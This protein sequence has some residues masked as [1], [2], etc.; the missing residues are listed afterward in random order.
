METDAQVLASTQA[1]IF[2]ASQSKG[3]RLSRAALLPDHLHLAVG[4]NL[5]ES[6]EVVVMGYLNNLAF[7]RGMQPVFRHGYFAGTF[8]EYDLGVIPRC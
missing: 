5:E 6:P 4:C 3:H 7:A 8:C 1:M 2:A